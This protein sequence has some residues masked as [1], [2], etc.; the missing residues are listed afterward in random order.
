MVAILISEEH[1]DNDAFC[2]DTLTNPELIDFFHQHQMIVWGGNVRYTEAFQVSHTLQ[3]TTYPFIAIIALQN[4]SSSNT[5]SLNVSKMSVVDRIEGLISVPL[6]LCRFENVMNRVD[7]TLARF[8]IERE[9]REAERRLR[10]EQDKAY[11]ESLRADQLKQQRLEEERIAA[12]RIKERQAMLAHQRNQYIQYLC[13]HVFNKD[14][15]NDDNDETTKISFRLANGVRVIR[16]FRADDTLETLYQFIEAYPY[17]QQY[18]QQNNENIDCSMPE[19]YIHEY[20]FKIHSPFP[21][22]V[23]EA[24]ANKRI[25]DESGLWPSATLIIDTID[26]EEL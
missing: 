5:S 7:A 16:K 18:Q 11:Q 13:Q 4:P 2:R 8:R 14:N 10:E 3:A 25:K 23:Y 9:Q 20:N 15:N 12:E 19:G 17:L 22:K 6:L 26:E 24:D 1:D 21:R